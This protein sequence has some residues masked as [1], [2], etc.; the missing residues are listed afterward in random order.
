MNLPGIA[1][2]FFAGRVMK[3]THIAAPE[4]RAYDR[5]VVPWLS[6][7][8]SVIEPPIGSNLVAIATKN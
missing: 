6:R 4:T 5:L 7:V 3:K 8:E 2:W 1:A